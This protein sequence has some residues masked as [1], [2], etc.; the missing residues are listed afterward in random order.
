[1]PRPA[2]SATGSDRNLRSVKD[3]NGNVTAYAWDL[4][5]EQTTVTRADG[6]PTTLVTDYNPDGTTLDQKDGKGTPTSTY[7]YDAL[8]RVTSD[9]DALGD[10]TAFSYTP[11]NQVKG[12]N[13]TNYGYDPADNLVQ[14]TSGTQ[15]A[16][17]AADELCWTVPA[18][19]SGSCASPRPGQ[20]S[21][22]TR[23]PRGSIAAIGLP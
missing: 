5:N 14:L 9:I 10:V 2:K 17:N 19:A 1:L 7:G 20:R 3:A 23:M 18:A 4:A 11:L 13:A 12:V 21:T 15:Q 6:P 22:A 16:F 8:G